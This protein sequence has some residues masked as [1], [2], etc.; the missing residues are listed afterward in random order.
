VGSDLFNRLENALAAREKSPGLSLSDLLTLP[1]QH[2]KTLKW[3]I[4]RGPVSFAELA[5]FLGHDDEQARQTLAE[6]DEAAFV[7]AIEVRGV[8]HYRVRL[9]PKRGRSLPAD[10]WQALSDQVEDDHEER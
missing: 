6:L 8:T 2:S 10:L 7:L 4:Q 5:A 9:A 3:M 1:E